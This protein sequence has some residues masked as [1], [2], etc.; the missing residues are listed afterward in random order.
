MLGFDA[1]GKLPLGVANPASVAANRTATA[2]ITE[3]NDTLS[4]ASV[5]ASAK[6]RGRPR[7]SNTYFVR[8]RGRRQTTALF[9]LDTTTNNQT[10]NPTAW[11]NWFFPPVYLAAAGITEAD[12][13]VASAAT[14][15]GSGI[16]ATAAITEANDTLASASQLRI[17]AAASLTE[18]ADI[19][20]SAS[21]LAI[22]AAAAITEGADTLAATGQVPITATASITEDSDLVVSE[23]TDLGFATAGSAAITE[24]PDTVVVLGVVFGIPPRLV[25]ARTSGASSLQGKLTGSATV[26]TRTS[27]QTRITARTGSR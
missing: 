18:A 7:T 8:R 21:T 19:L 3:A 9:Y 16:A 11:K 13:T 5:K 27:G 26:T 1:L 24:Q 17:A 6:G 15:S 20:S 23:G 4:A 25:T 22:R 2:F 10:P 12:D 14:I